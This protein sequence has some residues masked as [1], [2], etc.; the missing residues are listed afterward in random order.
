MK[1]HSCSVSEGIYKVHYNFPKQTN[2]AVRQEP[3]KLRM[4]KS[5]NDLDSMS[6]FEQQ[7]PERSWRCE[8]DEYL[9]GGRAPKDQNDLEYWKMH[10]NAY[11]S[12]SRMARDY[13]AIQATSAPVERLFSQASLKIKKQRSHL[14]DDSSKYLLCLN[15][16]TK[17]DLSDRIWL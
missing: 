13:L 7:S 6:L 12:L 16:W 8:T 3:K 17:S 10:S 1:E 15:S 14:N 4:D 5:S 11:S 2:E 9:T